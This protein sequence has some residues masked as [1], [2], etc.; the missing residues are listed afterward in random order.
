VRAARLPQVCA[1]RR[2]KGQFLLVEGLTGSGGFR[3]KTDK[4]GKKGQK[5]NAE[6]FLPLLALLVRFCPKTASR[7]A[8]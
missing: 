8:H 6:V 4:K 3:A 7:L 1:P 5:K 2:R